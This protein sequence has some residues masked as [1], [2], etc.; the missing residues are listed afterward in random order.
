MS[1]D[2]KTY[3]RPRIQPQGPGAP[4][5]QVGPGSVLKDTY[6]IDSELGSGGMGTVYL[7]THMGLE[8]R[9]A[10][11]V[12]S[13]RAIASPESL[14]RFSREAKV[15]GKVNHPAMTHVI[16]YGVEKGTPYIVMEYVD[17]VELAEYIE[18]QGPMPARQ[19]VAVMR[20]IVSL[21]HVAHALGIV[22]RDLKPANIKVVQ[23][24]PGD[25]QLFV[26]VLDFGIAKVLGDMAGQLTSE[27]M[28]VG[29]PAYMAPEQISGQPID[30]RTDLYAAGLIFH[31]ML[32]GERAFK[33]DT[34][35]RILHAQMNE[36]PPPVPLPL[37]Q[38]LSQ[39][40]KKFY[41]KRPED[42]FQ[43][44]A[45][46]DRALTACEETLRSFSGGVA[47]SKGRQNAVAPLPA[48]T[49]EVLSATMQRPGSGAAPAG[50]VEAGGLSATMQRPGSGAAPAGAVEAGGLS[51]TMQRPGAGASGKA[52]P[53][54]PV[55][56][57]QLAPAQFGD[58]G[59]PAPSRPVTDRLPAP[60]PLALEKQPAPMVPA[61]AP[62]PVPASVPAPAPAGRPAPA[63]HPRK[64]S[65][66]MG[67][68]CLIA[69]L[70]LGAIGC[71]GLGGLGFL[72]WLSGQAGG[73]SGGG[74]YAQPMSS[75]GGSHPREIHP[76]PS[77]VPQPLGGK[78]IFGEH[79]PQFEEMAQAEIEPGCYINEAILESDGDDG[80]NAPWEFVGLVSR[81][82]V[83]CP[84]GRRG[85]PSAEA[86]KLARDWPFK[87]ELIR[88]ENLTEP[89]PVQGEP[90]LFRKGVRV[91]TQVS[92]NRP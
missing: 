89:S 86:R 46:A 43:D 24:G 65:S 59:R 88:V 56:D 54:R 71:V 67:K 61:P 39:T 52:S 31:E 51:A 7:S 19:A 26:K 38:V 2:D 74:I 17:G 63:Q 57:R 77:H 60:A 30:G 84:P 76:D 20:Q 4:A 68:G 44:A 41:E 35:A 29:T 69:G 32:S 36:P 40:L 90:G 22:H 73:A 5:L 85:K 27:G 3:Q 33:G 80:P 13:P 21:L 28:M 91:H 49:P 58:D 92:A 79:D 6:R 37:P 1:E 11:K 78:T 16:D 70:V 34:I 42:R 12:L 48:A 45:D 15:A 83:T 18:R 75:P 47:A 14:A 66:G 64:Q 23:A 50:A 53:S 8:K 72:A 10:V 62:V 25:G 55:T 9:M 87:E 81:E 82:E